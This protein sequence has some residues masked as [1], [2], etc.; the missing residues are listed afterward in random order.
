MLR[1]A[2][3]VLL[4][5]VAADA[6]ARI[7]HVELDGSGDFTDIQPAVEA[8]APGDTISIGPGR[9]ATF[10]SLEF[11]PWTVDT[12]VGV[13]KDG[14]RFTGAGYDRTFLGSGGKSDGIPQVFYSDGGYGAV[15]ENM[16]I[17][18]TDLGINW[19]NGQLLVQ[20][21]RFR[22]DG[23][24][25]T[26]I[27][28]HKVD[29][30][31]RDCVFEQPDGGPAVLVYGTDGKVVSCLIDNCAIRGCWVGVEVGPRVDDV[32]IRNTTM[33][34]VSTGVELQMESK[35][36]IEHCAIASSWGSAVLVRSGATIEI[37]HATI[38]GGHHGIEIDGGIVAGQDV[39]LSGSTEASLLVNYGGR[40][41]IHGSQILPAGSGWAFMSEQHY[42]PLMMIDLTNNFW[43]TTDA[44]SVAA[45]ICDNH[46]RR[47]LQCKVVYEPF[48]GTPL[49]TDGTSWGDLEAMFR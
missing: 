29:A 37:N 13:K 23:D 25:F 2:L 9:F 10:R 1:M 19:E 16:T 15:I 35:G 11:P 47:D 31:V 32:V 30:I 26:G 49:P 24:R 4:L 22:S 21:C 5:F 6:G 34:D 39:V 17:E 48:R 28:I 33:E 38:S 14:L 3:P 18:N 42:G 44:A 20:S 12:I 36:S 8:A 45:A 27:I 7:W 43:G 46:C 40:A 41:S